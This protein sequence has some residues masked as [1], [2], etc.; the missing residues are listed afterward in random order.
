MEFARQIAF[1][2]GVNAAEQCRTLCMNWDEVTRLGRHPLVT[3]AGHT[4]THPVLSRLPMRDALDEMSD[5]ASRIAEMTGTRP[6][7]FSYPIGSPEAAGTREFGLAREVGFATAVTTRAGVLHGEHA[8]YLTA[9]PR[10][11]VNGAF[12]RL[13]YVNV[14]LSGVA[15]ALANGFRRVDAA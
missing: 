4:V 12:Q 1:T 7:H 3:I 2:Y 5:S 11:S 15:T 13:R 10:I 14:L 6:A 9:L 8:D